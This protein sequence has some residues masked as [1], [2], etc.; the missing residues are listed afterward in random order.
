MAF[1]NISLEKEFLP[2]FRENAKKLLRGLQM[3]A[4]TKTT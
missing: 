4:D 3:M 1:F 2:Q